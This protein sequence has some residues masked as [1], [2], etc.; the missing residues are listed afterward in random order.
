MAND[1]WRQIWVGLLSE[2]GVYSPE[3]AV[4]HHTIDQFAERFYLH[5]DLAQDAEDLNQ[6]ETAPPGPSVPIPGGNP[7]ITIPY[8]SFEQASSQEEHH[9]LWLTAVSGAG[10]LLVPLVIS[11]TAGRVT[12]PVARGC[13]LAMVMQAHRTNLA[14]TKDTQGLFAAARSLFETQWREWENAGVD[15]VA[16]VE[17]VSASMENDDVG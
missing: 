13:A 4:L 8:V 11:R 9:R 12:L 15:P 5:S 10:N 3:P 16:G 1:S 14:A 17:T 6:P 7:E 2:A